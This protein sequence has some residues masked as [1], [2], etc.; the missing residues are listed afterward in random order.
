MYRGRL[1]ASKVERL[2][3][4]YLDDLVRTGVVHWWLRQVP[5]DLGEDDTYRVDFVTMDDNVIAIDVKGHETA[6]FRRHKRLWRKYG[7]FPLWIIRRTSSGAWT[8]SEIIER[9]SP[10]GDDHVGHV[11]DV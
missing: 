5:I 8:T 11:E 6:E 7:P 2:Y 9:V 1:Y 3:A 10:N 4:E